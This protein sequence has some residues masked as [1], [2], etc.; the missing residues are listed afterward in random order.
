M[1]LDIPYLKKHG[2]SSDAF[3]KIFTQPRSK[4]DK[5]VKRLLD[6]MSARRREGMDGCLRDHRNYWTIDLAY[7]TPVSQTTSTLIQSLLSRRM[8]AKGTLEALASW[9]LKEGDLFI[10]GKVDGKDAKILNPPVFYELLVPAVCSYTNIVWASLYNERDKSPLL[11]YEPRTQTDKNKVACDIIA[12]WVSTISGWY[13]YPCYMRQAILQMLKYGVMLA[14]T[15]EEWHC[16]KQAVDGEIEIVKEGLRYVMPHPSRMFYDLY[17]PLW[18]INTATGC[19]FAGH[20]DVVRAGDILDNKKYWN[21]DAIT[22]GENWF[23]V[24][25]AGRYF[26]EV[27]PCVMKFPVIPDGTKSRETK[28]AYYT[29]NQRDTALFLTHFFW[30]LVPK[31]WGLGDYEHPVWIRFIMASDDTII[32]AEP[33]AYNPIWF[34]GYDFDDQAGTPRSLAAEILPWQAHLGNILTEMV[35]TAKRNICDLFAYDTEQV[36]VV[37]LNKLNNLGDRKYGGPQFIPASSTSKSRLGL[38]WKNPFARMDIGYHSTVELQQSLMTT[39]TMMERMLQIT[40]QEAGTVA[41]HYQ[42]KTEVEITNNSSGNRRR[43]TGSGIDDGTDAWK[44]QVEDASQAYRE[45]TIEAQVSADIPDVKKHLTELGFK[46]IEDGPKQLLVKGSKKTLRYESFA[47]TN[48][49]PD[50]LRDPQAAQVIFQSLGQIAQNPEV[51]QAVGVK[52]VVKILEWAAKLAGAPREFD[53]TGDVDKGENGA[54]ALGQLTPLLQQMQASIMEAVKTNVVQPTAEELAKHEQQIQQLTGVVGEIEKLAGASKAAMDKSNL[55]VREAQ[56]QEQ[57][58]QQKFANDE[59]RKDEALQNQISRQNAS[60]AQ[61]LQT[62][63]AKTEQDL[64]GEAAKT[65]LELQGQQAT[66]QVKVAAIAE[67]SA[68]KASVARKKKPTDK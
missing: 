59:R 8:D 10:N 66:T 51:F 44:L 15:R 22:F 38:D 17:H 23:S 27:F 58:D 12:D 19:E 31:Q 47:R 29:D 14:F 56:V 68:A 39:L 5:D 36:D 33:C 1:T 54:N 61:K 35:R 55:M 62:D 45:S 13:G 63:A 24:P 46:V 30:K 9:G 53:I 34:M 41:A 42:S 26:Q 67:Q 25:S 4:W 3:K 40:S 16:E 52:R 65:T 7:D 32:W 50:G 43:A 6:V 28:A 57:L 21:R 60:T 64:R 2:V 48:L 18:T 20:W 37:D 11:T 49:G